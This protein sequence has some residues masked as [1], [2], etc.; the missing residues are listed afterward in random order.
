M[1][2]FSSATPGIGSKFVSADAL[3]AAR[4]EREEEAKAEGRELPDEKEVYDP[5][6]LFERLAEKKRIEE[7]EFAERMRFS[8]LVKRLDDDEYAFLAQY[9]S[10]EQKRQREIVESDRKELEAFRKAVE[11]PVV[12][13]IIKS[14]T[15]TS[16][17]IGADKKS[18]SK[19][20]QRALLQGVVVKKRRV[21]EDSPGV[22]SPS[23]KRKEEPLSSP[24]EAES[25]DNQTSTPRVKVEQGFVKVKV[26]SEENVEMPATTV[27]KTNLLGL[28]ADYSSDSD[29]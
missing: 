16:R 18:S 14:T 13:D 22:K 1:T 20:F 17:R 3:E 29:E 8:N 6:P 23:K 9:E 24:L 10:E 27:G 15:S 11:A 7:E 19:D 2:G 5:R 26:E 28:L 4:N 21:S 25:Q 12:P